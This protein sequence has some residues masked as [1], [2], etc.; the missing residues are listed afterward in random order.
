MTLRSADTRASGSWHRLPTSQFQ[1]DIMFVRSTLA[2]IV[3]S[4]LFA[5]SGTQS[6]PA[7]HTAGGPEPTA[8]PGLAA[9]HEAYMA[10]DFV[11]VGERIRD[12]LL[13]PASGQLAKD[14]ALELLDKAYEA[15]KGKLP[16]AFAFPADVGG[17]EFGTMN[18]AHRYGTYREIHL[19]TRVRNGLAAR[20]T[21]ITVRRLPDN[22]VLLDLAS[23]RGKLR[24]V[25][26]ERPGWED[27]VLS[28][29]DL[30]RL[31]TSG[32]FSI[33]VEVDHAALFDTWFVA[34]KLAATAMPEISSPAPAAVVSDNHPVIQWTPFR[35]PEWGPFD[36]RR[37]SVWVGDPKTNEQAWSLWQGE[38]G[39]LSRVRIGDFEGAPKKALAP[40]SYWLTVTGGETRSFGPI[41]IDR[42]GQTGVPFSVVK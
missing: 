25:R 28:S 20:I 39:E 34:N 18:G 33:R 21:N 7:D 9:A 5:C 30:D 38:A 42:D 32:V 15:Q 40:G 4:A 23:G 10:G 35:S 16:S 17:L 22:D 3:S 31:P 6:S 41:S 27:V 2:L 11:A 19:W 26:H 36:Q 13:D 29:V 8:A 12:V 14:N 37:L 24:P 1:E